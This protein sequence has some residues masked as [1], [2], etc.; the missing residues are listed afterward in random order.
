[1]EKWEGE[2]EDVDQRQTFE[3]DCAMQKAGPPKYV[4]HRQYNAQQSANLMDQSSRS[5]AK[6]QLAELEQA[7]APDLKQAQ[8]GSR[9]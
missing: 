9:K 2:C 4:S 3:I 5:S 6:A 1:M 7:L 8:P